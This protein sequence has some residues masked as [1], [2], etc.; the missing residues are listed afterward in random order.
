MTLSEAFKPLLD[1]FDV[2]NEPDEPGE[3]ETGRIG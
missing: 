3:A 2:F 1:V